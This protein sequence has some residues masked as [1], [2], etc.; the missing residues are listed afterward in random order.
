MTGQRDGG[1]EAGSGERGAHAKVV[2]LVLLAAQAVRA[3]RNADR[4]E[5]Q[6]R[7]ALELPEVAPRA[8]RGRLSRQCYC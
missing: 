1:R 7:D 3:V 4:L 5:A 8:Q 2:G 6:P